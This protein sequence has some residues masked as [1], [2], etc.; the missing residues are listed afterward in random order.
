MLKPESATQIH[1]KDIYI[2]SSG[3]KRLPNLNLSLPGSSRNVLAAGQ[4]NISFLDGGVRSKISSHQST[5]T[6]KH[7]I[8]ETMNRVKR[9]E[10]SLPKIKMTNRQRSLSLVMDEYDP[11]KDQV[12]VSRNKFQNRNMSLVI[13]NQSP[14]SV[15]PKQNSFISPSSSD[16]P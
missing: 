9:R 10:A 12:K 6:E 5:T 13:P 3:G 4:S 11:L 16:I 14:I 1:D 8:F 15:I 2:G 7:N